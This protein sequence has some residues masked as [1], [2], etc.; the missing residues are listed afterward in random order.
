M[1]RFSGCLWKV[2]ICENQT[3]GGPSKRSW[4]P[5]AVYFLAENLLHVIL[6]AYIYTQK[7]I[8]VIVY[9]KSIYV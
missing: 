6:I 8:Y 9:T 7:H 5:D 4:G 2:V 3:T 1:Q